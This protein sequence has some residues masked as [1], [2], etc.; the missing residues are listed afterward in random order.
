MVPKHGSIFGAIPS[1]LLSQ[2][3]PSYGFSSMKNHARCRLTLPGTATSTNPQYISLMYDILANL[4][5]NRQDSRIILNRGL[6]EATSETGLKV[7]SR[8]E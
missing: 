5:M 3:P 2:K 7:R 8:D 4:T 1:C 6:V